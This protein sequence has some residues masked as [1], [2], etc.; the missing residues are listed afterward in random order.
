MREVRRI[1]SGRFGTPPRTSAPVALF[2]TEVTD[3]TFRRY[4]NQKV[5]LRF[6]F[7]DGSKR[8][9]L[10]NWANL[11]E[12]DWLRVSR[13]DDIAEDAYFPAHGFWARH[14]TAPIASTV[15][16]DDRLAVFAIDG[17]WDAS[18]FSRFYGKVADLYA[19]LSVTSGS[20]TAHLSAMGSDTV[21]S[22][23]R[24]LGWR[25]G[26]S[27]VGFYDSI[28]SKVDALSPLRVNRIEYASPGTIELKG[29]DAPLTDVARVVS[30]FGAEGGA[31]KAPYSQV[32]DALG[33]EDLRTASFGAE[34]S[35]PSLRMLVIDRC[36][37]I[38]KGLGVDAPEV[39]FDLC[40]ENAVVFAKI[41]LSFFRR[42]K[43]LYAFHAEGRVASRDRGE[44]ANGVELD[45]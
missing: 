20:T 42:A 43:E 4:L 38:N 2:L 3:D 6:L 35:S 45:S 18:D 14:H 27:Y 17:S 10:A 37:E 25:G 21:R 34:F 19:F 11:D 9:Y 32:Y 33:K 41:T 30:Q 22:V 31:L 24:S 28:F 1:A 39:L 8:R 13:A 44:V 29:S 7:K 36:F 12:Q 5:D 40:D 23:I 15:F 16:A 26:G